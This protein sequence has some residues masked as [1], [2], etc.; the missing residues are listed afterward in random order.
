MAC[1]S[2]LQVIRAMQ[3]HLKHGLQT[4][5]TQ[6]HTSPLEQLQLLH[7]YFTSLFQIDTSP[8]THH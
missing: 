3:K 1:S 2:S 4:R 6:E 8:P 7:L 5:Q